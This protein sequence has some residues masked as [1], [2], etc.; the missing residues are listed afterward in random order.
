MHS[1]EIDA[2]SAKSVNSSILSD[3]VVH[4]LAEAF[5]CSSEKLILVHL[6]FTLVFRTF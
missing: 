1:E 2:Q 5:V 3:R 6:N 4:Y